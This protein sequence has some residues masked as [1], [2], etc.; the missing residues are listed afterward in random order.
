[1]VRVRIGCYELGK[2]KVRVR[3]GHLR[4]GLLEVN[5]RL[6]IFPIIKYLVL[7]LKYA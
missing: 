1:M 6:V 2:D 3:V 4:L 5:F 7:T